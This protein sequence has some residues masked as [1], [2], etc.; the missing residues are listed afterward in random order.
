MPKADLNGILEDTWPLNQ[1]LNL[2]NNRILAFT[3]WKFWQVTYSV[4]GFLFTFYFCI[5]ALESL[6]NSL[7]I[8]SKWLLI[9]RE[10]RSVKCFI[11]GEIDFFITFFCHF[12]FTFLMTVLLSFLSHWES[13]EPL[14]C[15]EELSFYKWW[16]RF[17]HYNYIV[18]KQD[19]T[20]STI[21]IKLIGICAKT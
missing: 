14:F 13:A 1:L 18:K 8:S 12:V 3:G 4:P 7:S 21:Q 5:L 2:E 9:S 15:S 6:Q 20:I 16:N 17:L 19:N 10:K 11:N